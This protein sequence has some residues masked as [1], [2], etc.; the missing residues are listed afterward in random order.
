M[1]KLK[2]CSLSI[3]ISLISSATAAVSVDWEST[4]ALSSGE[5]AISTDGALAYAYNLGNATTYTANA[6]EFTGTAS[7]AVADLA[8]EGNVLWA[9]ADNGTTANFSNLSGDLGNVMD[10]AAWG[11]SNTE[12]TITLKNLTSDR[13]YSVQLFSSDTRSGR[14][15]TLVL[16]SGAANE[17]S[18]SGT[19]SV[20]SGGGDGA[21]VTGTFVTDSSGEA[22]FTFRYSS[23]SGNANINAIQVRQ[24]PEPTKGT[25]IMISSISGW[26]VLALLL[27]YWSESRCRHF[28]N[29]SN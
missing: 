7:G 6:V 18:S 9:P 29:H 14:N 28:G 22:T 16:D 3:L 5:S 8:G 20:G 26:L 15:N 25:V 11:L 10:S 27:S 4:G 21:Y 17:F 19:G 23:S 1:L 2:I 24:L 13:T 12:T